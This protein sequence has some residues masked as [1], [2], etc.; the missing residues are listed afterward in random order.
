MTPSQIASKID[1]L[2]RFCEENS[3]RIGE[4]ELYIAELKE[5]KSEK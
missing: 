1:I 4:L 3:R 5:K 2:T